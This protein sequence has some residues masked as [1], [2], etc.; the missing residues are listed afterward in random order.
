MTSFEEPLDELI[1][2]RLISNTAPFKLV[3]SVWSF[4]DEH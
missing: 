1:R 2:P 4:P 3:N